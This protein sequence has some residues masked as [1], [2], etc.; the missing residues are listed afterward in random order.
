MTVSVI[1]PVYNMEKYIS[2]CLES[3]INSTYKDLEIICINDGSTDQSDGILHE[4]EKRDDRIVV[5]KKENGGISSARNVGIKASHGDYISFIDADDYIHPNM[6]ELL[7]KG[8]Q[9]TQA[10]IS[11]CKPMRVRCHDIKYADITNPKVN[12]IGIKEYLFDHYARFYVWG[13]L[14]KREQIINHLFDE[15]IEYAEDFKFNVELMNKYTDLQ[16][17]CVEEKLYYYYDRFD[18]VVNTLGN[19]KKI[20][21]CNVLIDLKNS[22]LKNDTLNYI[23]CLEAI[24]R[25]LRTRYDESIINNQTVVDKCNNILKIV[26]PDFIKNRSSPLTEKLAFTIFSMIP[27]S[28]R[29]FRI[30]SDPTMLKWEKKMRKGISK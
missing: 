10:D 28:Y 11:Y 18:S 25:S 2:L 4:Y 7:L 5:I 15:S 17:A 13:K 27:L 19:D 23:C 26:I 20:E 12:I 22:D 16:F 21:F 1:I 6:I 3:V 29:L 24:K 9:T 8:V 14:Y 30:L